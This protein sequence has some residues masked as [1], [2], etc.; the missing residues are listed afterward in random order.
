MQPDDT[1][2]GFK[3]QLSKQMQSM[4]FSF[5]A[6]KYIIN[7]NNCSILQVGIDDQGKHEGKH[8][9]KL[10]EAIQ[11]INLIVNNIIVFFYYVV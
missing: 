8:D 3:T 11:M 9:E 6:F 10:S 2:G 5:Q 1:D 7:I 4:T